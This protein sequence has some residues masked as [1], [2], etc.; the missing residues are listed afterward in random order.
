MTW[1][2]KKV[3]NVDESRVAEELLAGA[4]STDISSSSCAGGEDVAFGLARLLFL[5]FVALGETIVPARLRELEEREKAPRV[6]EEDRGIIMAYI[7]LVFRSSWWRV[8]EYKL[9]AWWNCFGRCD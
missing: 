2:D 8:L 6:V 7:C 4:V 5:P 3:T 1:N 9:L